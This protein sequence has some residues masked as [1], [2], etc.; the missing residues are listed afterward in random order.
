MA[1]NTALKRFEETLL[2]MENKKIKEANDFK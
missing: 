1:N 2:T